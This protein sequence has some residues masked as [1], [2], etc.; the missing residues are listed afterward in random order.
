MQKIT[1]VNV[2]LNSAK[3]F[4]VSKKYKDSLVEHMAMV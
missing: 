2:L 4:L 1:T 3:V